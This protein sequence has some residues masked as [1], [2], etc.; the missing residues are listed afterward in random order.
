MKK[1]LFVNLV[2]FFTI[3]LGTSNVNAQAIKYE[4]LTT[5]STEIYF[6]S[7]SSPYTQYV[8]AKLSPIPALGLINNWTAR[9]EGPARYFFTI[10]L[11][12]R[13][14][15]GEVFFQIDR[16]PSYIVQDGNNLVIEATL[17]NLVLPIQKI[18]PIAPHT[19]E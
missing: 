7:P 6:S 19:I 9:V 18:I 2:F 15:N 16:E 14:L 1:L 4:I 11:I 8:S 17:L 10:R 5:P 3:M 12:D 13:G